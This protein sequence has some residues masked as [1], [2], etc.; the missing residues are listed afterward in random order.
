MILTRIPPCG[1]EKNINPHP[2]G[3]ETSGLII[4]EAYEMVSVINNR[5]QEKGKTWSD[6]VNQKDDN[7]EF[8]IRGNKDGPGYL[9]LIGSDVGL[10]TRLLYIKTAIAMV[11]QNGGDPRF[12]YWKGVLQPADKGGT[13]VRN[14]ARYPG[15]VRYGATD[16]YRQP[17]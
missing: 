9:K 6:V 1:K 7:G 3:E 16:F 11:K 13:F 12:N 4:A 5:A 2:I 17:Y 15:T 14:R 8:Q 10:C